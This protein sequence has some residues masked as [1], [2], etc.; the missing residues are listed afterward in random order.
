[1]RKHSHD[2]GSRALGGGARCSTSSS[3]LARGS[4]L[5]EGASQPVTLNVVG[6]QPVDP[7]ILKAIEEMERKRAADESQNL[8]QDCRPIFVDAVDLFGAAPQASAEMA[9][10]TR[11]LVDELRPKLGSLAGGLGFR[12]TLAWARPRTRRDCQFFRAR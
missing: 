1:M 7:S 3:F 2:L 4:A 5:A 6:P 11:V 8:E 12:A 9:G 10:I